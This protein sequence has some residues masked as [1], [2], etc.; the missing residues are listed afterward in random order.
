MKC[1]SVETICCK[2][3]RKCTGPGTE[4]GLAGPG[5]T[6]SPAPS[7]GKMPRTVDLYCL[8]CPGQGHQGLVASAQASGSPDRV[9][10]GEDKETAGSILVQDY[11]SLLPFCH[12]RHTSWPALAPD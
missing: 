7:T 4:G 10:G 5:P 11:R 1:L 9:G 3:M 2:I 8:H 6:D 12:P